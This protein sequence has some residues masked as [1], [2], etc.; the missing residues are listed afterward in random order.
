MYQHFRKGVLFVYIEYVMEC[1]DK[2]RED[3]YSARN[4]IFQSSFYGLHHFTPHFY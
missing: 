1:K 3:C 2:R 4:T